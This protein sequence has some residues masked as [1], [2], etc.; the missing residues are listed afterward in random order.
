MSELT[1]TPAQPTTIVSQL[2]T[3]KTAVPDNVFL[4]IGGPAE[5]ARGEAQRVDGDNSGKSASDQ[6]GCDEDGKKEEE[7]DGEDGDKNG[8]D[9]DEDGDEHGEDDKGDESVGV[10]IHQLQKSKSKA[11]KAAAKGG[12]AGYQG[13]FKGKR[14][15]NPELEQFWHMVHAAFWGKFTWQEARVGI[16]DADKKKNEHTV[17]ITTNEAS[18]YAREVE[19]DLDKFS[20]SLKGYFRWRSQAVRNRTDNL[21][22]SMLQALRTPQGHAPRRLPAWQFWQ[23]LHST[24]IKKEYD[25]RI[26]TSATEGLAL[27]GKIARNFFDKLPQAEQEDWAVKAEAHWKALSEK[28]VVASSSQPSFNADAQHEARE[29]LSHVVMPLLEKIA[30]YTGFTSLCLLG[31]CL[32]TSGDQPKY[33]VAVVSHGK[34]NDAVPRDIALFDPEAFREKFMPYYLQFVSRTKRETEPAPAARSTASTSDVNPIPVDY[35]IPTEVTANAK[36]PVDELDQDPAPAAKKKS[37]KKCR[38]ATDKGTVCA[39]EQGG[40][41]AEPTPT[42]THT[43]R[44]RAKGKKPAAVLRE[45]V[46][47]D[48]M[49][50][51][52]SLSQREQQQKAQEWAD[53]PER[54]W[55]RECRIVRNQ[56]L[57]SRI[58][59]SG[60]NSLFEESGAS[61]APEPEPKPASGALPPTTATPTTEQPALSSRSSSLSVTTRQPTLNTADTA[62]AGA[63]LF[64]TPTLIEPAVVTVPVPPVSVTGYLSNPTAVLAS[65]VVQPV[66]EDTSAPL[67]SQ[68][69]EAS[70]EQPVPSPSTS[71]AP[72]SDSS[73]N[74][75]SVQHAPSN[76]SSTSDVDLKAIANAVDKSAWPKWLSVQY[77]RLMAEDVPP[78]HKATWMRIILNWVQTEEVCGFVE[79]IKNARHTR[80]IVKSQHTFS[81]AWLRW[82]SSINPEWCQRDADGHLELTTRGS[83][84]WSNIHICGINGMVTV[85]AVLASYRKCVSADAWHASAADVLWVTEELLASTRIG[86]HE[87]AN[88]RAADEGEDEDEE[89]EDY[90][91]DKA[92]ESTQKPKS[93]F[94]DAEVKD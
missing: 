44:P 18:T 73:Q 87:R 30:E 86:R 17:M 63:E 22:N 58:G 42:S 75:L 84:N 14:G 12:K 93:W 55:D 49:V 1:N 32:V 80:V 56:L 5:D 74:S 43:P 57:L 35:V 2:P 40:P 92:P 21:W 4:T 91:A 20:Q 77:T 53:L 16:K 46:P 31:G 37:R 41:A 6:V 27:H 34:T 67:S 51:L 62:T 65:P 15:K 23:K 76:T 13:R 85:L 82:W 64:P 66:P 59:L 36:Q 72:A 81:A 8:K 33:S 60:A 25:I 79:Q 45:D 52:G 10:D 11:Q 26:I 3:S 48:I 24:E 88:K 7:E 50:W 28:Y 68:E 54:K 29:R 89:G 19:Q 70:F 38:T 9:G 83:G 71:A 47:T 90:I 78:E 61:R 94:Q 39:T 69:V